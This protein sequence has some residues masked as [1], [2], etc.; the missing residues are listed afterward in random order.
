MR[1][2]AL[3]KVIEDFGRL[4]LDDRE[5]ASDLIRK[6][7]IEAKREAIYNRAKSALANAKKGKI[8]SGKVKDLWKD[9]EDA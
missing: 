1:G 7:L 6:Q 2:T 9:L 8:K 5:Y 3:D 4:P